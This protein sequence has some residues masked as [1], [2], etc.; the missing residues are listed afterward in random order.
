MTFCD[1]KER[2]MR[3]KIQVIV[4]TLSLAFSLAVPAVYAEPA[5]EPSELQETFSDT[6]NDGNV[7][8]EPETEQPV[9]TERPAE[10]ENLEG[11]E[12]PAE[13][14]NPEKTEIPKD[15]EMPAQT[16]LPAD[17]EKTETEIPEE[18]RD[19]ETELPEETE[20]TEEE[21]VDG[22]GYAGMSYASWMQKTGGMKFRL[23]AAGPAARTYG[24]ATLRNSNYEKVQGIDVSELNTIT[25]WNKIKA[26]GVQ[27]VVIR[28]GGRYYRA[29][30]IY[31]DDAF[32][33]NVRSAAKA[34]LK[35]GVYFFS[36]AI[37]EKEAIEEADYCA[38]KMAPFKKNITLP[39]FMDYEWD[40]GRG[41]RL[42]DRGGTS[43][44]RTKTINAFFTE[45]VKKGY[46]PGFYSY[47]SLLG[48]QVDGVAIANAASIWIAHWGVEAP[49]NAY[50]GIYDCWQYSS[51]GIVQG[52]TGNVDM[53]YFYLPGKEEP[54]VPPA[55]GTSENVKGKEG[56]YTITSAADP[57]YAI[58]TGSDGN[59][60]LQKSTGGN[61]QR[62]IIT[63]D[64]S[65]RYRITSF[66]NGKCFDCK[67]GG[68]VTGTNIQT[69]KANNTI[70]QTW[71]LQEASDG[72]YYIVACNSGYKAAIDDSTS[73]IQLG[74]REKSAE[75]AFLLDKVSSDTVSEGWYTIKCSVSP[76]YVL[77]ISGGSYAN[78]ANLQIYSNNG[79]DAQKFYIEKMYDGYYRILNAK[80]GKVVD[81]KSK[82]TGD[83]VN[84]HQYASNETDAQRWII[85][86]N[87]DGTLSFFSKC[88][89]RTLSVAASDFAN[90]S[91]VI[92]YTYAGS[93]GQKF[94]LA[95]K[96][97]ASGAAIAEGRYSIVS[98]GNKKLAVCVAGAGLKNSDNIQLDTKRNAP[99]QHFILNY[100]GNGY[101]TICA[102][103]SGLAMDVKGGSLA[104]KANMQQYKA[105]G[106]DA[107][108]WKIRKNRDGT[109]TLISKKS[110]KA[111]DVDCGRFVQNANVQQYK[112]NGTKAQKFYFE[113]P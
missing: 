88:G 86:K 90:K 51:E 20:E 26:G 52:I 75:Q 6:E 79:T 54:P 50:T 66:L 21:L 87:D 30:T 76:E 78:S 108:I 16:E 94:T 69:Y 99:W 27:A 34:G 42:E 68:K 29:G 85:L 110:G 40:T 1:I 105:N 10:T 38:E 63:A 82:G 17:F 98:S 92:Q 100:L 57:G 25:D 93:H 102:N 13:A 91:N 73:N 37:N 5:G 101:Y 32:A 12:I 95:K 109:F 22:K 9:V 7:Y 67:G 39:V 61:D 74:T 3:K 111:L 113:K 103:H 53:D 70:A 8:Y 81:V 64:S 112:D 18:V 45:I 104:N 58:T 48:T 49:G 15:T 44:Q 59:L 33:D 14:E 2:L 96:K 65:G 46:Q 35:I 97:T 62:F 23:R 89:N 106:T 77:D 28:V 43:A 19:T 4:L 83:N 72:A 80:S 47:D 24:K 31:D 71:L 84:I 41:W 55:P 107:Q 36:Q 56:I 60:T 11:T